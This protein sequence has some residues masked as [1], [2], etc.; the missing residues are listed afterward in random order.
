MQSLQST[1]NNSFFILNFNKIYISYK[2]NN[3]VFFFLTNTFFLINT[4]NFFILNPCNSTFLIFNYFKEILI[5]VKKNSHL[6][7]IKNNKFKNYVYYY[8]YSMKFKFKYNR[9]YNYLYF[10]RLFLAKKKF[11]NYIFSNIKH[12]NFNFIF[13]NKYFK[14]FKRDWNFLIGYSISPFWWNLYSRRNWVRRKLDYTVQNNRYFFNRLKKNN[15]KKKLRKFNI[16]KYKNYSKKYILNNYFYSKKLYQKSKFSS[17]KYIFKISPNFRLFKK[18]N[19][20][21]FLSKPYLFLNTY[22]N[23]KLNKHYSNYLVIFLYKKYFRFFNILKRINFNSKFR[24]T[25]NIFFNRIFFNSDLKGKSYRN[26]YFKSYVNLKKKYSFFKFVYSFNKFYSKKKNLKK[27]IFYF[28]FLRLSYNSKILKKNK[29]MFFAK[30]FLKRK[31]ILIRSLKRSRKR[32][33]FIKSFRI[34][35]KN[36]NFKLFS[37][38]LKKFKIKFKFK[39]RSR[40]RLI[41]LSNKNNNK[42]RNK[43]NLRF[44]FKSKKLPLKFF[45]LNFLLRN[46]SPK[47]L[48]FDLNKYSIF[49]KW[50]TSYLSKFNKLKKNKFFMKKKYDLKKINKS[51]ILKK[52]RKPFFFTKTRTNFLLKIYGF[53]FINN[54]LFSYIN[55]NNF[56]YQIKKT[57]YSF[58]Y[59]NEIQRFILRRYIKNNFFNETLSKNNVF[60]SSINLRNNDSL[61]FYYNYSNKMLNSDYKTHFSFFDFI[62]NKNNEV[63]KIVNKNISSLMNW[64]Y[65]NNQFSFNLNTFKDNSEFNIKRVRFKPGYMT[66]WRDV[67]SVLKNSLALDFRYQY[68][69]TNYLAKYKKFINFRTFVFLEMRL[70]NILIKSRLF[71]DL[72]LAT[73]FVKNNLVYLNGFMCDNHNLQIFIGDFIQIVI[74]LK[75]YILSRWFLNLNLKKRNKIKSVFRKKNSTNFNSDE[76]KKSYNMP[77]WILFNKNLFDDCPSYLEVDYFTLSSFVLY[78]PFL[79]SDINPYNLLE[80]KFSI[81]NLYNWKYIT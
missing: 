47:Y 36:T 75:Y 12:G 73:L 55:K 65:Y 2:N 42:F 3:S 72:N 43:V 17:L 54:N 67:R 27:K 32:S 61:G 35:K 34:I 48:I 68:K 45:F 41:K 44:K 19:Y 63:Q 18:K 70:I 30:T 58:S 1:N 29:S 56:S 80:Q 28:W 26:R 53:L 21:W 71:N 8:K 81:I 40:L 7:F 31:S 79:W 46:F 57:L 23:F 11:T 4:F 78:E 15:N 5:S 52:T 62:S 16:F 49:F 10:S 33:I 13:F 37:I 59:K 22:K 60:N 77:K 25:N 39:Y 76:K 51:N 50:K 14:N 24:K 20:D 9:F 6:R 64:N 38:K 66:L 69:L 74:N